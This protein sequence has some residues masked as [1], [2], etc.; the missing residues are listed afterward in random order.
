MEPKKTFISSFSAKHFIDRNPLTVT[1][2][3]SLKQAIDLMQGGV[4]GKSI[5]KSS[6]VLV[7]TEADRQLLGWLRQ[8]DLVKLAAMG[9][10]INEVEIETVMTRDP[11]ALLE[12]D[13]KDIT[14]AIELFK[15]HNIDWLPIIDRENRLVG[16]ITPETILQYLKPTNLFE[17][18]TVAEV[19]N[20]DVISAFSDTYVQNI[21]ELMVEH[22]VSYV[23]ILSPNYRN[24][25]QPVGIVTEADIVKF[26][27][28]QLD[29]NSLETAK[30]M[31]Q[32][33]FNLS[34]TDSLSRANQQMQQ[35]GLQRLV[36]ISP[37]SGKLL[38]VITQINLLATLNPL[39]I[40]TIFKRLKQKV[41]RLKNNQK[42]YSEQ[43]VRQPTAKIEVLGELEQ[44]ANLLEKVSLRI[45]TTQNIQEIL[46][47]IVTEVRQLLQ[48]ERVIIY[49]FYPNGGG[50][51]LV[52]SVELDIP[53]L[54][55]QEISDRTFVS[56]WVESYQKGRIQ[57]ISD[58]YNCGLSQTYLDILARLN[59]FAHLV[60][61]IL[62][63]EKLWGLLAIQQC[64]APRFWTSQEVKFVKK[65]AEGIAIAIL[66]A[67]FEIAVTDG[68]AELYS[69]IQ[70]LQNK[71][72]ES[73][74]LKY[75]LEQNEAKVRVILEAIADIVLV[76]DLSDNSIKIA[77]NNNCIV[78][79]QVKQCIEPT[80]TEFFK[81][82]PLNHQ[83]L[84][85]VQKV[86]ITKVATNFEYNLSVNNTQVWFAASISPLSETSVVWVARDISDRKQGQEKLQQA[87]QELAKQL[88]E[89]ERRNQDMIQLSQIVQFLQSCST[90][91]E[92]YEGL[93]DIISP[94]FPETVGGVF[95]KNKST[96]LIE[97]VASWGEINNN[98]ISRE[99]GK[100][101][102]REIICLDRDNCY[103][104][105]CEIKAKNEVLCLPTIS[106]H[107]KIAIVY[108]SVPN[109]ELFSE[110]K[111]QL[112]ITVA[113][114]ISL[115]L[116]NLKLRETLRNQSIRDPLTNLFNR[117]YLEEYLTQKI[118]H[119]V[120]YQEFLG[121]II[122]DIDHF[123]KFN[124]TF[125]HD[126]GDE[127]LRQVSQFIQLNIRRSDIACRYG[128]EE[129]ITILQGANLEQTQ[130]RA[131]QIRKGIKHLN[132]EYLDRYLGQITVSIG[133]ASFPEN[134]AT[135]EALIKAAD[136]ALYQAKIQGRDRVILAK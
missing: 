111:R 21:V 29:L 55:G 74:L 100:F 120:R 2:N 69:T 31:T 109:P 134:G 36:V 53:S 44:Q 110:A 73:N 59:I 126:A 94:L 49:K 61:P 7:I 102:N 64:N 51:V 3:T 56:D 79:S 132:I 93:V 22:Q 125:G 87:N 62:Q 124:D 128:G 37:T 105:I 101:L 38:G 97:T 106:E 117:R 129:L 118:S 133:V 115:G 131:E 28:K 58:I 99:I 65:L 92:A 34:P 48:A 33:L 47:N 42:I 80:I 130:Q 35:L 114:Q 67:E 90:L 123:K 41:D 108:F 127:V 50:I 119:S 39:D 84:E 135:P 78:N 43:E 13:L 113:E 9:T 104:Y 12:S 1:P 82:Y 4:I 66:P 52:E 54:L 121:I 95:I 14:F 88:E 5:E 19:M 81:N 46:E 107:K 70:E 96:D 63:G 116:S 32:P 71:I 83:F 40:D 10:K 8:R 86:L 23:V 45:D 77:S 98:Q 18:R 112:T 103:Q 89:L 25:S 11:I 72:I 60:V 68:R 30:V 75:K 16:S 27:A 6:F 26:Q 17:L 85:Q 57:V 24:R 76:I 136:I 122:L 15:K 91:S 20:P